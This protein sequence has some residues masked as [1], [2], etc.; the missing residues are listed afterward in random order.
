MQV[1]ARWWWRL[2]GVAVEGWL[3]LLGNPILYDSYGRHKRTT[4]DL[5]VRNSKWL[6]VDPLNHFNGLNYLELEDF[7][8]L[9]L[10]YFDA[11]ELDLED[12]EDITT[13]IK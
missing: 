8:R 11:T 12:K 7:I 13:T 5:L 9:Y 6:K 3:V 10:I 1:D 4:L 2:R